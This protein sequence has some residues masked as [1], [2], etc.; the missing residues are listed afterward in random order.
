MNPLNLKY[1]YKIILEERKIDCNFKN[2][3]VNQG[4]NENRLTGKAKT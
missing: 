2:L 4:K 3:K 1:Y